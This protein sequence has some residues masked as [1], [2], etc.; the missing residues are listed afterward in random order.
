LKQWGSDKSFKPNPVTVVIVHA[1]LL[2]VSLLILLFVV[3][4]FC[5]RF[6]SFGAGLPRLTQTMLD[7]SAF[8]RTYAL[9]LPFGLMLLLWLDAMAYK[10]VYGRFGR[11][12]GLLWFWGWAILLVLSVLLIVLSLFLPRFATRS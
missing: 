9:F 11:R 2:L 10:Y 3:P 12:A 5:D 6:S 8:G 4:D 7:L 1:V